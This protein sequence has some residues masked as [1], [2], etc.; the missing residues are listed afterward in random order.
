MLSFARSSLALGV[1]G[2]EAACAAEPCACGVAL[3]TP[4]PSRVL[5]MVPHPVRVLTIEI[6]RRHIRTGQN[7]EV[8]LIKSMGILSVAGLCSAILLRCQLT[9]DPRPPR[10]C[11]QLNTTAV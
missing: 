6:L 1:A 11:L 10:L 5:C 4:E 7:Q 9:K 3:V 8:L 2:E